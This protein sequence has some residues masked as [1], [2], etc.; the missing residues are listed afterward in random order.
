MDYLPS[1]FINKYD[2]QKIRF[3]CHLFRSLYA[4]YASVFPKVEAFAVDHPNNRYVRQNLI[5]VGF[6]WENHAPIE[7]SEP[8]IQE[9]L[10]HRIVAQIPEDTSILI[11]D[12]APVDCL[13]FVAG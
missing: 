8:D 13:V 3:P 11:D 12:F 1:F 7:S 2:I 10:T 5:L 4:T 9:M 6:F